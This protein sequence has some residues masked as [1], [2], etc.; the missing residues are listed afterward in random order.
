MTDKSKKVSKSASSDDS[1]ISAPYSVVR[2]THVTSDFTWEV[3]DPE[4]EFQ[5]E[6]QIGKGCVSCYF[7]YF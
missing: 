1:G 4:N 2:T 6:T 3:D 7:F 5:I